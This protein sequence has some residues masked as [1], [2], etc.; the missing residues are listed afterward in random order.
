MEAQ[1]QL[2]PYIYIYINYLPV[3]QIT[4]IL[5]KKRII[6][7]EHCQTVHTNLTKKET[8]MF[9]KSLISKFLSR[10]RNNPCTTKCITGQITYY[11]SADMTR[12]WVVNSCLPFFSSSSFAVIQGCSPIRFPE[13]SHTGVRG[14]FLSRDS[15]VIII[16][17]LHI[18]F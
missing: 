1:Q 6:H 17:L 3:Y 10:A 15:V 4:T 14:L 13:L 11:K 9:S 5:A 18:L 2:K 7:C 8:N 16:C 12:A